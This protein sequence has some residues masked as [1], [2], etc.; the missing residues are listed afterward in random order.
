MLICNTLKAWQHFNFFSV[1]IKD[2]HICEFMKSE[3][4]LRL[5]KL[6]LAIIK[7]N[8]QKQCC[9]FSVV[10]FEKRWQYVYRFDNILFVKDTSSLQSVRSESVGIL[11]AKKNIQTIW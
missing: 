9:C 1:N 10:W 3:L 2:I 7:E 4:L 8:S 11:K 6:E 5:T